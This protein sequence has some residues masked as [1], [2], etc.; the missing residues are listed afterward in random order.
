M[1]IFNSL[2]SDKKSYSSPQ[3]RQLFP[4]ENQ[5]N[6]LCNTSNRQ[7]IYCKMVVLG[8]TSVGKTSL[9][10]RHTNK[11]FH[12]FQEPTIGA[13]FSTSEIKTT[14][15]LLKFQIWDTA[16]QERYRSLTPMYYRG[17][18]CA[19]VVYDVT[20]R[21]SFEQAKVW[22]A[23]LQNNLEPDIVICVVGNKGDMLTETE[24]Q[25][26]YKI[27]NYVNLEDVM[28]YTND[29]NFLSGIVS[30]KNG[31]GIDDI[32]KILA[33]NLAEQLASNDL[34]SGS[35]HCPN[36][37]FSDINYVPENDAFN[38]TTTS[39]KTVPYKGCCI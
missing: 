20:Q 23:E 14:H 16:G 37:S 25:S 31:E 5:F 32:F 34:K 10:V 9:V 12:D 30:A 19:M 15:G 1:N 27:R 13:A 18:H 29:N 4:Y 21:D 33:D 8:A 6:Y 22:V 35:E 3:I 26:D 38:I 28:T 24:Q 2:F 17:A 36:N 39:N 11:E 7:P